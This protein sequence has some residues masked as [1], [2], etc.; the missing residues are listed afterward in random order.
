MIE[1]VKGSINTLTSKPRETINYVDAH[2]NYT[3][4]DHI[5]K[6]QYPEIMIGEYRKNIPDNPF[7]S[8]LV[9]QNMLALG[10]ILTSQGIPFMQGGVEILRTK[11]AIIIA[12]VVAMMLMHSTGKIKLNLSQYL[13][14][15]V[16]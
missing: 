4:W 14:M 6:S 15:C 7:D 10:I 3:L 1:G 8:K 16:V 13:I 2:D 12:T 11:M 5:E 9:Q